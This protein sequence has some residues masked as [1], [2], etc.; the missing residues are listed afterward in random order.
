MARNIHQSFCFG[1]QRSVCP[2]T[3]RISTN[4]VMHEMPAPHRHEQGFAMLQDGSISFGMPQGRKFVVIRIEH[5]DVALDSEWMIVET[6][7]LILIKKDAFFFR[8]EVG[9]KHTRVVNVVME[10]HLG[11]G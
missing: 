3:Q 6:Y 7:L 4:H 8:L 1:R 9:M 10:R 11:S 5:I 2:Q